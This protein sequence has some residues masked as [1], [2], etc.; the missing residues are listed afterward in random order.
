[1]SN[2]VLIGLALLAVLIGSILLGRQQGPTATPSP[3]SPAADAS[4]YAARD[5]EVIETGEDGLPIY[6]LHA[7][8]IQQRPNDER[9]QLDALQLTF[10]A[11]DGKQWTARADAG[12]IRDG[13]RRID[14]FG[15]V[16]VQGFLPDSDLPAE[17]HTSVLNVDTST[18]IISTQVPVVLRWSGNE[19]EARSLRANLKERRLRLESAHGSFP[20]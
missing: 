8:L 4:G 5:A 16:V 11:S 15:N 20:S 18:E 2:R 1:M 13:G 17:I 10:R 19:I 7:Q 9:V 14:L 3:A 6:T 12:Q